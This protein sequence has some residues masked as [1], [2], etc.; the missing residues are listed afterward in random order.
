M[1]VR[2]FF[3]PHS[4]GISSCAR[5]IDAVMCHHTWS[6]SSRA[7][8]YGSGF[9]GSNVPTK[10]GN[11]SQLLFAVRKQMIDSSNKSFLTLDDQNGIPSAEYSGSIMVPITCLERDLN[12]RP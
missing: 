4:S 8:K 2:H 10:T 6:S 9:F 5:T 3:Y 11:A 1:C 12:L 7:D